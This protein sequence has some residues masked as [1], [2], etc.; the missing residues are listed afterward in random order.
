MRF[1][2]SYEAEGACLFVENDRA[3]KSMVRTPRCQA[4]AFDRCDHLN[5]GNRVMPAGG[6][7]GQLA[8]VAEL[9]SNGQRPEAGGT[10]RDRHRRTVGVRGFVNTRLRTGDVRCQC[11]FYSANVIRTKDLSVRLTEKCV[12]QM[13]VLASVF[14]ET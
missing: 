12:V 1:E 10:G 6:G 7:E 8:P 9:T 13:T 3:L 4:D 2:S 5:V 11:R 14:I